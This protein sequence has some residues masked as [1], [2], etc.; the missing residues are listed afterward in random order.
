MTTKRCRFSATIQQSAS[1][2]NTYCSIPTLYWDSK[3]TI[4]GSSRDIQNQMKSR[5]LGLKE[6]MN[7][8]KGN[9]IICIMM[10]TTMKPEKKWQKNKKKWPLPKQNCEQKW[11]RID[12]EK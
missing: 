6:N 4:E 7:C 12:T 11:K 2:S 1:I 3:T 9:K 8:N 5:C 10:T